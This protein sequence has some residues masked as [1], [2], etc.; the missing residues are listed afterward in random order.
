MQALGR[1]ILVEYYDCDTNVLDDTSR[2]E[3]IL[4]NGTRASGATIVSQEFHHFSPHGV[5]GMVVIAES[6]VSVHTWPEYGYAAVD[7]F[8]CGDTIDP[9]VIQDYI[10]EKLESGKSSSMELKRGLFRLSEGESCCSNPNRARTNRKPVCWKM[11]TVR[12]GITTNPDTMARHPADKKRML[13]D[14]TKLGSITHP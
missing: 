2:I 14:I 11:Q 6:H 4:M 12:P 13:T 9:W 3:E 1:H 10:K 8:T 5:S 7:I